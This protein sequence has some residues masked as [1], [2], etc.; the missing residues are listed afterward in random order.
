MYAGVLALLLPLACSLCLCGDQQ[1]P[2]LQLIKDTM[3]KKF[4][5]AWQVVVGKGFSYDVQYEV[6]LRPGQHVCLARIA[7]PVSPRSSPGLQILRAFAVVTICNLVRSQQ[8][9]TCA[10]NTRHQ[11]YQPHP[12]AA[13]QV[14]KPHAWCTARIT[15]SACV[16][17]KNLLY[18]FVGGSTGVLLW[19]I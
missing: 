1:G 10:S 17:V 8:E 16:Q 12:S 19:K 5:P 15:H 14:T 18:M 6:R 3:D 13:V 9:Y 2:L 4:G 7:Q 11:G